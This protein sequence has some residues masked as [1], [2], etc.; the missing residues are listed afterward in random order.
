MDVF[1][2]LLSIV[3]L[4]RDLSERRTV[5]V[6]AN[7]LGVAQELAEN[8]IDAGIQREDLVHCARAT[9]SSRITKTVEVHISYRL[10]RSRISTLTKNVLNKA[11]ACLRTA[12]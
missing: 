9:A 10:N 5:I 12:Q 1:V 3:K 8:L 11:C 7:P 6:A 2:G 4:I